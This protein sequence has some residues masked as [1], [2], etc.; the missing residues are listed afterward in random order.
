MNPEILRARVKI[1]TIA[2][3][4]RDEFSKYDQDHMDL[5]FLR[6]ITNDALKIKRELE[7]E[8]IVLRI[9]DPQSAEFE[10]KYLQTKNLFLSFIR[11]SQSRAAALAAAPAAPV[12]SSALTHKKNRVIKYEGQTLQDLNQLSNEIDVLFTTL[13]SADHAIKSTEE[14]F[15]A[16]SKKA[17]LI[18][19]EGSSL[20]NDAAEAGL[21][22]EASALEDHVRRVKSSLIDGQSQLSEIK[23]RAGIYGTSNAFKASDMKP[24]TFSGD[25]ASGDYYTFHKEYFEF[26][27]SRAYT[28]TQHLY[29]LK[30]T[31][32]TGTAKIACSEMESSDEIFRYLK[33]TYGNP[34]LLLLQKMSEFKRLGVCPPAYDKKRDWFIKVQQQLKQ[35]IKLATRH[36]ILPELHHSEVLGMIHSSLP[37]KAQSNFREAVEQMDWESLSRKEMF[38]E[39]VSFLDQQV[40]K[41]SS[42]IQLN[43]MLGMHSG[44]K[45]KALDKSKPVHKQGPQKSYPAISVQ[46]LNSDDSEDDDALPAPPAP[47]PSS[48]VPASPA[49][50]PSSALPA[51]PAAPNPAYAAAAPVKAAAAKRTLPQPV[52]CKLCKDKHEHL[53]YCEKFQRARI[54]ERFQLTKTMKTCPR[55]LRLDSNLDPTRRWDWWVAHEVDCRTKWACKNDDC[56]DKKPNYQLHFTMCTR[57]F[58]ENKL[59]SDDFMKSLDQ[60][61]LRPNSRFFYNQNFTYVSNNIPPS[62]RRHPPNT[63]VEKVPENTPAIFL[64]QEII[65]PENKRALVFFDG[66]CS[67][68]AISDAGFAILDT[69]NVTKGPTKMGVAGGGVLTMPGGEERFWIDTCKGNTKAEI[70]GNHMPEITTPF[71]IYDLQAAY[72]DVVQY[73]KDN[74]DPSEP[75]PQ[76]PDRIG[77][78]AVD[79]MIGIKYNKFFPTLNVTLPCGLSLYTAVFKAPSGLQGVLGGPHASWTDAAK[80]AQHLTPFVF[81]TLELRTLRSQTQ[82]LYHVIKDFQH[83]GEEG[84]YEPYCG[85]VR[86]EEEEEKEEEKKREGK[87]DTQEKNLHGELVQAVMHTQPSSGDTTDSPP[88][89]CRADHCT[90]HLSE[91]GWT[92]PASWNIDKYLLNLRTEIDRFENLENVGSSISYRCLRCRNCSDCRR[93]PL[94]EMTSLEE[95]ADQAHLEAS[96]WFDPK[97]GRMEANLPFKMDPT[98]H[99]QNNKFQ[100]ERM[101]KAQLRAIAKRPGSKEDVLRAHNKLRDKGHVMAI[102][103]LPDYEKKFIAE[104]MGWYWI[105]WSVVFKPGSLSSPSR[106]VFNASFKTATGHSLNSLLAKG[107]NKLPKILGLL[108]Q[109]G[110]RRAGFTCDISMAYNS[111]RLAPQFLTYQRYLWAENLSVDDPVKEMVVRTLIYGV[112]PSGGLMTGGFEALADHVI[113]NYP[114]HGDGAMALKDSSYVDDI[115]RACDS[116][117]DCHTV[118]QSLDFVLNL[119]GMTTKG[120]TFSG[121]PPSDSVSSDGL[122]VGVLGYTWWPEEDV[123]SLAAKDLSLGK[124]SRGR[125]PTPVDGDLKSALEKMFTRRVLTGKVSGVYDPKGLVTPIT[126]RLKLSLSEIVDLK[127]G[128]DEKIPGRFLDIWVKNIEDIQELSSLKFKRC[129]IHPNA[130]NNKI[131]LI[132]NVDASKNVAVATVHAQTE[133]PDGQFACQLICAKS[134]LVHLSTIPR[135]ELRAAVLGATLAHTVKQ[136]LGESFSDVIFVTDSQIVLFWLNQDQRPLHTLVRNS[137]IEVRRLSNLEDWYHVD[138]ANNIAD[139]GT[140]MCD[141]SEL[142]PQSSWQVGHEWMSRAKKDMPIR[143]V[144]EIILSL[145]EKREAALEVKAQDVSGYVLKELRSQVAE[146]YQFSNYLVDPCSLPWPKS[147]RVMATVFKFIALCSRPRKLRKS[148]EKIDKILIPPPPVEDNPVSAPPPVI[149]VRPSHKSPGNSN[150]EPEPPV[151]V[152]DPAPPLIENPSVAPVGLVVGPG[153]EMDDFISILR[154]E[155]KTFVSKSILPPVGKFGGKIFPANFPSLPGSNLPGII[156]PPG[157]VISCV[158]EATKSAECCDSYHVTTTEEGHVT[159]PPSQLTILSASILSHQLTSEQIT[160]AEN[161]FFTKAS[162]E[163]RHFMKKQDYSEHTTECEKILYYSGRILE[164]QEIDD[165]EQVMTDLNPLSFARPVCDRYSP[166]AYSVMAHSHANLVHHRNVASSLRESRSIVFIFRGRDLSNEIREACTHCRRYKAKL[167]QVEMG[168][169]HQSRLRIS[170]PF[171]T[172]QCDLFGPYPARCEHNH[173]ATVPIWGVLFK[174]PASGALSACAMSSYNTGAFI[175][176]YGRHAYRYGHPVTVYCDAGTQILKACREMEISWADIA[177]TLNS[178]HDVGL[179]HVIAPV[180][181][182]NQIGMVERSVQEVKKL[183]NNVFSGLR[184]DSL[185]YE[186]AFQF[187]ANELNSLPIALGSKY[188]NLDHTDLITPSRL[189]LGRNNRRAPTGYTRVDSFSRQVEDLDKVHKSWWK[190]WKLERLLEYIPRPNKW[191]KNTREPQVDDIVIFLREDKDVT[192]GQTLWR[193]GRITQVVVS[194]DGAK[195]KILIEYRNA[196]EKKFRDTWRSTRKVAII[197]RESDLELVEELNQ[198]AKTAAISLHTRLLRGWRCKSSFCA[199]ICM[200]RESH[201]HDVNVDTEN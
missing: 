197:H 36:N 123:I 49:L 75:L 188:N 93:G 164:G 89:P 73:H 195:R 184:L 31:C 86:E 108:N 171:F 131:R 117:E 154:P 189:I 169:I 80:S 13:P 103:D 69:E 51:P 178:Q 201:A 159:E 121:L 19:K 9:G 67:T 10:E 102:A 44:E 137:V 66:G 180:L 38:E 101:L 52:Q 163:V 145:A 81:F 158:C 74:G 115:M 187:I 96:V 18:L 141:I 64:M 168:N 143:S 150:L 105:P 140:R 34:N 83:L 176:A 186:T 71:P 161:Y 4:W 35:L 65:T 162:S 177:H 23:S 53:F 17:D 120:Y 16:Y 61:L 55:C 77:G 20:C 40:N 92:V 182:H 132:V 194:A 100:A 175:Q 200:D 22:V 43:V 153:S 139:L 122:T 85:Y 91:D 142:G 28:K 179:E 42:D 191:L 88:L 135:G 57:H 58:R 170:P 174:C 149:D 97:S 107:M 113:E 48:A 193:L 46:Q 172:V 6:N 29:T 138:S 37:Y 109:F 110:L 199:T 54:K 32:L 68:A 8:M 95:E 128:W 82:A 78:V 134:K 39:T 90:K 72:A 155:A 183:F 3:S 160:A 152:H 129:F 127:L 5:P 130:I 133:L 15:N 190:T 59:I 25:E 146:R 45:S 173:R 116:L 41:A 147:V 98:V 70:V 114:Q 112:G 11:T 60:S 181:G 125:A 63:E 27:D 165:V 79:I 7:E 196:K 30:K 24:P 94:L 118:T 198:A 192:L 47:P 62:L 124:S 84:E 12:V 167:L 76:P 126:S 144:K 156:A 104:A 157:E 185:S 151:Q 87:Q 14:R 119:A 99:L 50:P 166:V 1:A 26:A 136:N 106:I 56:K 21:E 2:E 111:V 148:K 33:R